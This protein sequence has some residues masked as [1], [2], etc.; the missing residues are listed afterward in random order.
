MMVRHF[1]CKRNDTF[2]AIPVTIERSGYDFSGTTVKMEVRERLTK[3]LILEFAP[4]TTIL[5][6]GEKLYFELQ[7][8]NNETRIPPN[9]YFYDLE[10]RY[11]NGEVRTYLF[12][13]FIVTDDVTDE[14]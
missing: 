10:V 4:T 7:K 2:G 6:G 14:R 8:T 5:N 11:P 1:Y 9:I 12:G 3:R 13:N